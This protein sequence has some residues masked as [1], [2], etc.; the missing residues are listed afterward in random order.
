MNMQHYIIAALAIGISLPVF[1]ADPLSARLEAGRQVYT[2]VCASCHDGGVNGAPVT[3]RS[4]DWVGR[5]DNWEAVQLEHA[6]Q[7]YMAMPARGGDPN[8]EK[9]DVDAAAEYIL[10]VSHP[11]WARD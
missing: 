5:S 4:E 11:G 2:K 3:G 1:A 6:N 7:G 10:T 9:Y 8:L